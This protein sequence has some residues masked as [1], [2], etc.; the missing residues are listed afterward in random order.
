MPSTQASMP[1]LHTC[2]VPQ[3]VLTQPCFFS[4]YLWP[5]GQALRLAGLLAVVV[6]LPHLL[7]RHGLRHG[8]GEAIS[9]AKAP[10]AIVCPKDRAMLSVSA[11][12]LWTPRLRCSR[13][14]GAWG[15][16]ADDRFAGDVGGD[17]L[18]Q[19]LIV[20]ARPAAAVGDLHAAALSPSPRRPS[21]DRPRRDIGAPW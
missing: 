21:V 14:A 1:L 8:G 4:L 16:P 5:L 9:T 18:D 11:C 7:D 17:R 12:N 2:P 3:L 15:L 20:V 6:E 19:K 13:A 10:K